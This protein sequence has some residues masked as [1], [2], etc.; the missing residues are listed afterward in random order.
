MTAEHERLEKS[1]VWPGDVRSHSDSNQCPQLRAGAFRFERVAHAP[2]SQPV[3]G[4]SAT[5]RP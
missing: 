5:E 1:R 4:A 3:V 2:V